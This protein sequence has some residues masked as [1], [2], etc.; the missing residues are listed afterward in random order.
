MPAA[1]DGKAVKDEMGN[2]GAQMQR[3]NGV[4]NG[5]EWGRTI[6]YYAY[7]LDASG[8]TLYSYRC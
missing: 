5:K 4:K 2:D 7:E 3:G 6:Y 8:R 1:D